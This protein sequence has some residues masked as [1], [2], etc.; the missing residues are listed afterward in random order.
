MP[1]LSSLFENQPS[2]GGVCDRLRSPSRILGESGLNFTRET[3][4]AR[5]NIYRTKSI[6]PRWQSLA[7]ILGGG[8]ALFLVSY[9]L[10]R[11]RQRF[12]CESSSRDAGSLPRGRHSLAP[13]PKPVRFRPVSIE[14]PLPRSTSPSETSVGF[15]PY[16]SVRHEP[17]PSD[18]FQ[19]P[20]NLSL[21]AISPST[22]E[23]N[24]QGAWTAR[25]ERAS[26][27]TVAAGVAGLIATAALCFAAL[28]RLQP[29]SQRPAPAPA[30]IQT[31]ETI[32]PSPTDNS[33]RNADREPAEPAKTV[34]IESPPPVTPADRVESAGKAPHAHRR[35]AHRHRSHRP[36]VLGQKTRA[37]L[38]KIF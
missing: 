5:M 31:T 35:S 15:V 37:F 10:R 21:Q 23:K 11:S 30:G 2:R 33:G 28:G 27:R 17:L 20:S 4:F 26:Y 13:L 29:P 12:P 36:Q 14:H 38:R 32:P 25:H 19:S 6:D 24:A 3:L 18:Q 34:E 7:I 8:A 9:A 16:G 1:A 22:S